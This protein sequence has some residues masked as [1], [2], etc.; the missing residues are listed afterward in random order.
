[1]SH[2]ICTTRYVFGTAAAVWTTIIGFHLLWKASHKNTSF[3]LQFLYF[4]VAVIA[5]VIATFTLIDSVIIQQDFVT[6][7]EECWLA[8]T[9][10]V[11]VSYGIRRLVFFVLD[12]TFFIIIIIKVI[13]SGAWIE[14]IKHAKTMNLLFILFCYTIENIPGVLAFINNSSVVILH[15]SLILGCAQ[16]LVNSIIVGR[17][18]VVKLV[19]KAYRAVKMKNEHK[20]YEKHARNSTVSLP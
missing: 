18:P 1:M 20:S 12:A 3:I 9:E 14:S 15:T 13:K 8:Y 16:G 4:V 7:R 11:G 19:K 5:P 10:S 2:F 6:G 17:K